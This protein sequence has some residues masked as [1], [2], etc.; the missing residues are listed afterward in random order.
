MGVF[1][2]VIDPLLISSRLHLQLHIFFFI[3]IVADFLLVRNDSDLYCEDNDSGNGTT[4]I[5]RL[6]DFADS[7]LLV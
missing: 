3:C 1:V 4:D 2:V 7:N 5:S 6:H